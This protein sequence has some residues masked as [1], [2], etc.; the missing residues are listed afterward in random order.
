[1]TA[2]RIGA[3][4]SPL[5]RAQADQVASLLQQLGFRT[6]FVGITTTGDVDLRSLTQIG[7]T[8]V[9]AGAVRRALHERRI[10]LAVH[11]LKDL[12][13]AAEPGL[14]LAAIP[15]R[16]DARDVIVGRTIEQLRTG[17]RVGTGSPRRAI[18]LADLGRR[19]GI[20]LEIV[21]LRGNVDTRIGRAASGELAAVVLAAAGLL[22]LGHVRVET[23]QRWLVKGLPARPLDL[24]EMIPAPGQGALGLE[25]NESLS[26]VFQAAVRALD[27]PVTR[28]ESQAERAFLATLEAGCTAPVGAL[29][30]VESVHGKDLD[31]TLRV[32]IGKTLLNNLSAPINNLTAPVRRRLS[33]TVT[34]PGQFG[35]MA[36]RSVL[37]ELRP[38]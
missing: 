17:D 23:D 31:L 29:A 21:E 16:A 27:D 9:F 38:L 11:S 10:D 7:G 1:M 18:Q 25:I 8:G 4:T 32:V 35:A 20:E 15:S 12:P 26:N 37:G 28:A 24:D 6:E 19:L 34:D 14:E 2:I 30:T 3:R 22:R 5:A 36:A 33:G 13:T